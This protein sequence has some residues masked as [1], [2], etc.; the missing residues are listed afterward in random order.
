MSN[1]LE[2]RLVDHLF[3]GQTSAAPSNLFISLHTANPGDTGASELSGNGYQ[4]ATYAATTANWQ[5]T[6]GGGGT[7][8]SSG[9]GGATSNQNIIGGG[10]PAANDFGAPTSG[11]WVVTHFGIWDAVTGGNPLFLGQLSGSKTI[12]AGDVVTFPA[13]QLQ[14]TFA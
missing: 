8:T 13:G 7:N 12:N 2:N 14:I 5:P 3:R 9:T 6:Q 10:S 1:A 4:R 11:T